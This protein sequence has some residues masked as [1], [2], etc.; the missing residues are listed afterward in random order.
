M[1]RIYAFVEAATDCTTTSHRLQVVDAVS[2]EKFLVD[3]G[4]DI[5]CYPRRLLNDRR[6]PTDFEL[7]AANNSTIRTYDTTVFNVNLNLRRSFPWRFTV[8]DVLTPII[9]ADFL[10]Y[11][12]LLPDC[13]AKRLHDKTTGLSTQ[14]FSI[15]T[16]QSSVRL[17]TGNVP[18]PYQAIVAKFPELTPPP[19]VPLQVRNSTYHYIRTTPRPPV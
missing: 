11:F 1:T 12:Q 4:S 7:S 3:T 15:A 8:A 6:P 18:S 14:G 9:G 13:H 19:G 2:G 17:V 16:R 5:C 10:A